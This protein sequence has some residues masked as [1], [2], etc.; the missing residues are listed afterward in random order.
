ML[1]TRLIMFLL[2][3]LYIYIYETPSAHM[4]KYFIFSPL[5][6]SR[7]ERDCSCNICV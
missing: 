4:Y 1:T 2:K 5:Y 7:N 3:I 6:V